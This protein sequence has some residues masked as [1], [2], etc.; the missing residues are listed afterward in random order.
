[1]FQRDLFALTTLFI[2]ASACASAD[3][4][5]G[6]EDE[7]VGHASAPLLAVTQNLGIPARNQN[8]VDVEVCWVMSQSDFDSYATKRGWVRTA[9]TATWDE[10]AWIDYTGWNERCDDDD[11]RRRLYFDTS[12]GAGS[13]GGGAIRLNPNFTRNGLTNQESVQ[14]TAVHEFGHALGF[15]HPHLRYDWAG[16]ENGS[17]SAGE[18]SG[19]VLGDVSDDTESILSY[20]ISERIANFRATGTFLSPADIDNVQKLYGGDG[21]HVTFGDF[22]ALRNQNKRYLRA[23][24]GALSLDSTFANQDE[25]MHVF[26]VVPA[27]GTSSTK[28]NVQYGDYVRIVYEGTGQSLCA[29]QPPVVNASL[30]L[31]TTANTA[32]SYLNENCRWQ[33]SRTADGVGGSNV[34]VNDPLRFRRAPASGLTNYYLTFEGESHWRALGP[35]DLQD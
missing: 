21:R 18:G 6:T 8:S 29:I 34:D 25:Y 12:V 30:A 27:S 24:N 19:V 5:S 20:C 31:F 7:V 3:G 17:Q 4:S 28:T 22:F 2:L 33:I 15:N 35:I 11:S 26:K 32:S 9:V 23:V 13:T 1:M 10:V 14:M 16:C